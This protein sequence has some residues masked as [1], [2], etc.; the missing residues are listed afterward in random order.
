MV[1]TTLN[2]FVGIFDLVNCRKALLVNLPLDLKDVCGFPPSHQSSQARWGWMEVTLA[3]VCALNF[4]FHD[5]TKKNAKIYQ[6][7]FQNV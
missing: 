3:N 7:A 2:A 1:K 5:F 6:I 4:F